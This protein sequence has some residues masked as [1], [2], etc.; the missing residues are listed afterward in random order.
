MLVGQTRKVFPS[1]QLRAKIAFPM[2]TPAPMV[3]ANENMATKEAE[4]NGVSLTAQ[5]YFVLLNKSENN[6]TEYLETQGSIHFFK[7]LRTN[8]MCFSKVNDT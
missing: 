3:M 5:G 2:N 7:A 6:L 1:F 4:K 8:N